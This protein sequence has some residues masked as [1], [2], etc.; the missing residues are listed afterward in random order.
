MAHEPWA[1]PL[2]YGACGVFSV[3]EKE[4]ILCFP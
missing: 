2:T 3:D 1:D 4:R